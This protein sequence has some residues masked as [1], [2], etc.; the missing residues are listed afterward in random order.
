MSTYPPLNTLRIFEAAARL[1]SFSAAA[2]EL[3]VTHGA[4]S[5][6]IKQLEDWLGVPL[7]ERSG[8]R[9]K[10]T[11]PGWRYLVQV[12]DGLDLIANATSQLLQADRRRRVSV[13][14]TPTFA[15]H[16]LLPR[17]S[18]FRE[19]FP[20]LELHLATS[21]RDI[22]RLDSP[23]DIA[24]RR[25]PGDWP[26]HIAKPFLK[27]WELPLCGPALLAA[28]PIA[29]P[30]DLARHTLL[31]ADT[32]PTAW[33]RWLTLAGV[34]ELKPASALHFDSFSLALQAAI[35]GLGVVLG[36]MPMAQAQI[37]AGVLLSPL[38][39]PVA[40]VRD[41]CWVAPRAAAED[42]AVAAFCRWLESEAA[43]PDAP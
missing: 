34:P 38:P 30:A 25:G 28:A 42:A 43:R 37:D 11:D 33:Q 2:G 9:V 15:L 35:N 10:L 32:R 7:F 5:K 39:A 12:Q 26:G 24:I 16:W 1:E 40:T 41:Y 19:Q 22:S 3:F 21:D 36:P 20:E 27:E 29:S 8:G 4:V 17:L 23:F 31:Y 6:Q 13:N 18:R 14:S